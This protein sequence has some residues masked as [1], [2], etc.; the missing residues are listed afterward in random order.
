MIR[1]P[2]CH[3][4]FLSGHRWWCRACDR[5][6]ERQVEPILNFRVLLYEILVGHCLGVPHQ[7]D[8]ATDEAFL[9]GHDLCRRQ[10]LSILNEGWG[11]NDGSIPGLPVRV[12]DGADRG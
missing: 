8:N 4:H 5:E 11:E 2:A 3:R 1:M 9:R 12:V 10:V 7:S 6:T